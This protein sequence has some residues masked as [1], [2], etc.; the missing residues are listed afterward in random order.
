MLKQTCA[1]ALVLCVLASLGPAKAADLV[2]SANDGK[3]VRV[4]GAAT[5]PRPAPPDSLVVIDAEKSPPAIVATLEGIEHTVQGPPQA[6]AITPDGK[7]AVV[8]APSR[9]DDA[10][11]K[12]V[13]D[14]FLQ[15]VDLESS[16]PKLIGKVEI[17]G[18]PNGLAINGAGTLLLAAGTDG[19]VR[20]LSIEGKTV[21]LL[22]T[23]KL[24][25]RRLGSA[26]FTHDGKAA[27]VGFRDD[28]GLAVLN[29][30]G[31]TV[32]DSKERVS[33]G[34]APYSIDVASDGKS[35]VVSNV[36]L[37]GLAGFPSSS[38]AG[39]AD[40]V[41]LLDVSRRPFRAV[42]FLTVPATPEGVA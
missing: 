26:A 5:F 35:A 18:H 11:G 7:L 2:V 17:G 34:I 29:V 22:N 14:P 8:G 20:V 36:G 19:S 10:T 27:L 6:V 1:L 4:G 28:G 37:M 33:T 13:F 42:Q 21:K 9:W 31:Q 24:S 16:P 39:D 30:D 12:E 41:T 3:F 40:S 38:S 23:I 25:E 15:V 32:T